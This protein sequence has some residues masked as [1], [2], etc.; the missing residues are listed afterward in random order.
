MTVYQPNIDRGWA[1]VVMLA[2]YV[3]NFIYCLST[4][5]TGVMYMAL[6][7]RYKQNEGVT[8]FVGGLYLGLYCVA[9]KFECSEIFWAFLLFEFWKEDKSQIDIRNWNHVFGN[10]R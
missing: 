4:Y 6:L 3:A 7:D 1:W 5:V 9:G 2:C 10:A 8:S